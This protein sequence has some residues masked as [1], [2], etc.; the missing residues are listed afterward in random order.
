MAR[1]SIKGAWMGIHTKTAFAVATLALVGQLAAEQLT[2][3]QAI[4]AR[5]HNL[6][7]LG[8]AF[9]AVRDQVRKPQ[10][11]MTQVQQ[12]AEQIEQLAA[13]MKAWF[14]KGSEPSEDVE[15]D[16][17][18]EIWNDPNGF[19]NAMAKFQQE[20]PKLLTFAKAGD[21][22]GLRKQVATLGGACKGCHDKYRV[23]QD[24]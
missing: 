14:P 2:G 3:Q 24:E 10:P 11:D 22:A 7:D 19:A 13:D 21:A 17:K 8:G 9:K 12:A 5:Q 4:D 15:T 20:A 1:S 16:A 6:K 23:P 18:A